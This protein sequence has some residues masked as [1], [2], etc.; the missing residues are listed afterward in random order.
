MELSENEKKRR[1][2]IECF[3]CEESLL[4]LLEFR[5][6]LAPIFVILCMP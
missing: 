3:I 5:F 6:V 1:E 2:V 4:K